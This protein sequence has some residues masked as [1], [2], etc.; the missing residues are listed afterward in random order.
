ML[1]TLQAKGRGTCTTINN[2][3]DGQYWF[4][5][6]TS[7]RDQLEEHWWSRKSHG[8]GW[9]TGSVAN[10]CGGVRGGAAISGVSGGGGW[11]L[12]VTAF[13]NSDGDAQAMF[14]YWKDE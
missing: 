9:H 2:E 3:G 12:G 8:G 5:E 1:L 13:G 10:Q 14:D 7:G 11:G 6:T 4:N